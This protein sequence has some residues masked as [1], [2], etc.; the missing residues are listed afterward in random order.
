M[1]SKFVA[2]KEYYYKDYDDIMRFISYFY[3]TSLAKELKPKTILEVGVGN[4]TLFNYLKQYGF[5]IST[6]DIDGDLEPDYIA[7]IKKL[8]FEDNS[9]DIVLAYEILE[10][11]PWEDVDQ[12]LKEL[13]RVSK[14]YVNISIPYPGVCFELILK[15]PLIGTIFR[16]RFFDFLIKI[17]F[18]FLGSEHLKEHHW[19]M[20]RRKTSTRKVRNLI[21]KRFKIIKEVRPVLCSQHNFFILEKR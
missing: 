18:F 11:M 6:C 3:Q 13:H 1:I 17:P 9:Y 21:R 5:D 15:F 8:P 7:D 16:K 20:G 10:H 4:K 2:S 19:E 12:A 14:K